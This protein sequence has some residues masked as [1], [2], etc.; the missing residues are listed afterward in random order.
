MYMRTCTCKIGATLLQTGYATA[1]TM[2]AEHFFV[3]LTCVV[4]A[5]LLIGCLASCLRAVLKGL[6]VCISLS[7]VLALGVLWLA[8]S[9]DTQGFA[10][11]LGIGA[12][13]FS[14]V[15][16]FSASLVMRRLRRARR[17]PDD[18]CRNV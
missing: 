18:L 7:A 3:V 5:A 17:A 8:R 1:T 2:N 10:A 14:S 13:M 12:F 4:L 15:I 11:L 6:V 9:V 16:A